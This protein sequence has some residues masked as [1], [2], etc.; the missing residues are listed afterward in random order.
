VATEELAVME[1]VTEPVPEREITP[2]NGRRL[3][4]ELS[5]ASREETRID[6]TDKFMNARQEAELH[7]VSIYEV[8]LANGPLGI[9]LRDSMD[10]TAAEVE[11]VS[12]QAMGKINEDDLLLEVSGTDVTEKSVT[13]ALGLI[14]RAKRPLKLKF[15]RAMYNV[16]V[17]FAPQGDIGIEFSSA[18][19]EHQ[20]R[21][22]QE[23]A[24][25]RRASAVGTNAEKAV[26][27]SRKRYGCD[28]SAVIQSVTNNKDVSTKLC[29]A[30]HWLV[31]VNG[32]DVTGLNFEDTV[33]LVAGINTRPTQFTFSRVVGA[34]VDY[35]H[36]LTYG[37][38]FENQD[39]IG[40]HLK[41]E[42]RVNALGIG[43][44]CVV[45]E[46]TSD[47]ALQLDWPDAP[48]GMIEPGD[49]LI[50][51]LGG[52]V[53]HMQADEVRQL[54]DS[55]IRPTSARF[56]TRKRAPTI[57]SVTIDEQSIGLNLAVGTAAEVEKLVD[58]SGSED[59]VL[60]R[61]GVVFQ[62]QPGG[63]AEATRKIKPGHW[64]VSVNGVSTIDGDYDTAMEALTSAPRPLV[65]EFYTGES[66]PRAMLSVTDAALKGYES[67][68]DAPVGKTIG[69][70]LQGNT[71]RS[72]AN[73]PD[74]GAI[75]SAVEGKAG[76]VGAGKVGVGHLLVSVNGQSTLY[77]TFQEC[78]ALV[79]DAQR[80]MKLRFLA[81]PLPRN[82]T[83]LIPLR[84]H[85]SRQVLFAASIPAQGM[86]EVLSAHRARRKTT[87]VG[88]A[89]Y[90]VTITAHGPLGMLL[91]SNPT[92]NI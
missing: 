23:A 15:Q 92:G 74:V 38:T 11:L 31:A 8:V 43:R 17:Q 3:S 64:L 84:V 24:M 51:L 26:D 29:E 18:A 54:L 32:C 25:A 58:S 4:V 69:V 78:L 77:S 91:G 70:H 79:R 6:E 80:P 82:D 71:E 5:K 59:A 41:M 60:E 73:A 63:A 1:E 83:D 45:V 12:G 9:S 16:T 40:L 55:G 28:R 46:R 87:A 27:P 37:V 53:A 61:S 72:G 44:Q 21:M 68:V 39:P 81:V 88:T 7:A 66:L 86:D 62:L 10:W 47:Q 42:M 19:D 85:H 49:E 52:D 36:N 48:D 89:S 57:Y 2:V 13:E 65:L 14:A 56:I 75:V 35:G 67:V 34:K 30:G 76:G 50:H 90:E 33:A 20:T 22:E